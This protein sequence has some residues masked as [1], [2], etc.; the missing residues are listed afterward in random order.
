MHSTPEQTLGDRLRKFNDLRKNLAAANAAVAGAA[1]ARSDARTA[2]RLAYF[3]DARQDFAGLATLVRRVRDALSLCAA[4]RIQPAS[5]RPMLS[6]E[7]P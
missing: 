2:R 5:N 4:E 3:G 6:P 1:Q 7:V